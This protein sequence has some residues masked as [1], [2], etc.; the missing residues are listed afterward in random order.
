MARYDYYSITELEKAIIQLYT[1]I[2]NGKY[3]GKILKDR[4][5]QLNN[6]RKR[7]NEYYAH[8]SNTNEK[9]TKF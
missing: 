1:E 5:R 2:Q 9:S 7:K 3:K 8:R 4:Y 6:M